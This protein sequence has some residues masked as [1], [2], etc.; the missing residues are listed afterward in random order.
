[1]Y[2]VPEDLV[3]DKVIIGIS[4]M[5]YTLDIKLM[6]IDGTVETRERNTLKT[7]TKVQ[8]HGAS[9]DIVSNIV[10]AGFDFPTPTAGDL[11]GWFSK[12]VLD[13]Y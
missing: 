12:Q 10:H 11:C 7:F 6:C 9:A 4:H 13:H 8:N 1:M 2:R 3:V 5:P